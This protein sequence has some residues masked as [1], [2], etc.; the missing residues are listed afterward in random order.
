[1]KRI[2]NFFVPKETK[3][4]GLLEK[5]S[6]NVCLGSDEFKSFINSFSSIDEETKKEKAGKIKELEL[7]G[8][9]ISKEI[10]DLL[11]KS[12]ITPIDREDIHELTWLLDDQLDLLNSF[13]RKI[14]QFKVK[15]I[16][17][18]M[19]KQAELAYEAIHEVDKAVMALRHEKI[20]SS[21]CDRIHAIEEENDAI[22]NKAV[23]ELFQNSKDAVEII[24]LKDL[25]QDLEILTDRSKDTAL[26]IEGIVVKH[27]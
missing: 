10:T 9:T 12:F 3:F 13:S 19:L 17:E 11:H 21:F 24:K 2:L 22:H 18:L 6:K 4:F 1:M 23:V 25:Y 20:V 15:E 5:Q 7:K 16:P 27:A 14:V 26:V 8:D